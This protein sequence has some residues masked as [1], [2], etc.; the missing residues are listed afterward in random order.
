LASNDKNLFVATY[1]GGRVYQLAARGEILPKPIEIIAGL[2]NP[3]GLALE[4]DG[5][6]LVVETGAGRLSR[7]DLKT[8]AITTVADKLD[9]GMTIPKF[10]PTTYFNGVAVG[11][12]GTI[13]ITAD[14]ANAL[15]RINPND[16]C[17]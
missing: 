15:Y 14:R 16:P 1:F 2:K 9:L 8:G 17:R 12:S 4:L 6:L 13:Y 10:I 3:E 5:H 11:P 7:I